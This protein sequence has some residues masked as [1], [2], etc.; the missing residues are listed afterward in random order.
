MADL[1]T[2]K[3]WDP[4]DG[5]KGRCYANIDGNLEDL[6][7]VKD[8]NADVKKNKK[9]I[10]VLGYGGTKHKS[11][12]WEGTGKMTIYYVTSLFRRLILTYMK[13]GK[14]FYF[15]MFIE[16]EDPSSETGKQGIWLKNCNID[17]VTLAKLDI[18]NTELDEEISFTFD[19][20]SMP[21]E[22]TPVVG[23]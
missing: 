1:R 7:Y 2:L 6:I 22:F 12:G 5:A 9:S 11:T 21:D 13:E 15:D 16:N 18:N 3:A 17:G 19:D 20:A 4:I 8:V 23:E 10:R 14:D